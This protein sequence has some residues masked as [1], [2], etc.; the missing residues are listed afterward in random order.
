VVFKVEQIHGEK[1]DW[2]DDIKEIFQ[3]VGMSIT[4]IGI[5][6]Q[7][8]VGKIRSRSNKIKQMYK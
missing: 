5:L 2:K 6:I 3:N 1:R 7:V 4:D 8:C